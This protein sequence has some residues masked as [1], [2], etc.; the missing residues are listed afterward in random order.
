MQGAGDDR[1]RVKR[2]VPLD[3]NELGPGTRVA[4]PE[5]P[6]GN[7]RAK[8]KILAKS[9]EER[10]PPAGQFHPPFRRGIL[11]YRLP[12][13]LS[14]AVTENAPGGVGV[15]CAFLVMHLLLQWSVRAPHLFYGLRLYFDL[16]PLFSSAFD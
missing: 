4:H 6:I 12:R 14:P 10:A 5:I 9:G 7:R 8:I 3:A 13:N 1:G 16:L 2:Y 11:T 15:G